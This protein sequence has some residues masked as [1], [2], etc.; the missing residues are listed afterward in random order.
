MI[1]RLTAVLLPVS[2]LWLCAACAVICGQEV[3]RPAGRSLA[4]SSAKLTEVSGAQ[5]CDG[6]PFASFPKATAPA[7]ATFNAGS[8]TTLAGLPPTPPAC[9]LTAAAFV[10][11]LGHAPPTSPALQLLTTLRI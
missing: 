11:P 6:C 7:R 10:G 4:P 8:Q 5:V 1:K 3:G 2:F 9:S